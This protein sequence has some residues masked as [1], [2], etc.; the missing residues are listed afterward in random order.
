MLGGDFY[1]TAEKFDIGAR[2]YDLRHGGD[3]RFVKTHQAF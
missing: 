3:N 1:G 2:H